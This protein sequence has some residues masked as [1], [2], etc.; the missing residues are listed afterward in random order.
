MS[1]AQLSSEQVGMLVDVVK[2]VVTLAFT[3]IVAKI[4]S[5]VLGGGF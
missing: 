1:I 4:V 5:R 3:Y 2:V